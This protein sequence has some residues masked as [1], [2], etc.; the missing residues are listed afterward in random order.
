MLLSFALRAAEATEEGGGVNV[1]PIALVV[2]VVV[3]LAV[4]LLRRR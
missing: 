2:I 1:L 4:V 3:L